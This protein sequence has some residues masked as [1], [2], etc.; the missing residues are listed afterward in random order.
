MIVGDS[1]DEEEDTDS[2][3][4]VL[5]DRG[6]S[7]GELGAEFEDSDKQFCSVYSR[8]LSVKLAKKKVL[9]SDVEI[10]VVKL[11]SPGRTFAVGL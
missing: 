9:D 6:D 5:K 4:G 2:G 11:S 3:L 8:T 7:G 1:D 10:V